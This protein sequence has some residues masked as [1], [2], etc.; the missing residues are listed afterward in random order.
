LRD[1]CGVEASL[2]EPEWISDYEAPGQTAVDQE[3]AKIVE[4]LGS[5]KEQF[6]QAQKKR[7]EIRACLK[8]LYEREFGL[9]P[10]VQN[11]LRGLGAHVEDPKEANKEDGW[12]TV[13]VEGQVYEGVLEIKS[14]RSAQFGEDGIRQLLDWIDRGTKMRQKKYKGIFIGN[15]SVDTPGK[16]RPW[17]FSDG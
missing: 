1:V 5:A 9:E 8:L 10:A 4:E 2:P 17:P 16:E 14:T 7:E 15:S 3:I 12:V 11:I 13:N 6:V